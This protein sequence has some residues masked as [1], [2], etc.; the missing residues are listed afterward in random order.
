MQ[1]EI[2]TESAAMKA[3]SVTR[4]NYIK[5]KYGTTF[6]S[7]DKL[8]TVQGKADLDKA[9]LES[10]QYLAMTK[11]TTKA[12]TTTDIATYQKERLATLKENTSFTKL[13]ALY[14]SNPLQFHKI[15]KSLPYFSYL[16]QN[17]DPTVYANYET[18]KT[19]MEYVVK[20]YTYK[21]F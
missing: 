9:L 14:K 17:Q 21:T 8:I 1:T 7:K 6:I 3:D 19:N 4:F 15:M 20:Y 2:N 11:D 12:A 10:R 13:E 5:E 16:F 18:I